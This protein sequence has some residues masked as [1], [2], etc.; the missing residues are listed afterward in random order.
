[1]AG[2]MISRVELGI[3]GFSLSLCG[4][5]KEWKRKEENGKLGVHHPRWL[6][7]IT[8]TRILDSLDIK[9]LMIKTVKWSWNNYFIR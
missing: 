6:R 3:Y 7:H 2:W 4:Y 9:I 5:T 8:H 1:M